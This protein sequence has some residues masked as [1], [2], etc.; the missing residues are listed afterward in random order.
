MKTQQEHEARDGFPRINIISNVLTPDAGL[1][2]HI[3]DE[4]DGLGGC[5]ST[6]KVTGKRSPSPAIYK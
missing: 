6:E 3:E 4:D 1:D 2:F 5:E